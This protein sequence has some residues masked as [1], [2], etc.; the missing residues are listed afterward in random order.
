MQ[1]TWLGHS[2]F[3]LDTGAQSILI[4]PFWTGNPTFPAGYEDRVQRSTQ[5][6]SHMATRTIWATRCDWPRSTA[7]RWWR[8]TRS[9]CSSMARA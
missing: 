1:L 3:H 7:P 8:S 6:C 9:A 2:A 4:D 5:S